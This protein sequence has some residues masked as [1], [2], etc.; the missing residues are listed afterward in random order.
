M[1][2]VTFRHVFQ[3]NDTTSE[4]L[5]RR[6]LLPLP[7]GFDATDDS[8]LAHLAEQGGHNPVGY[9]D[10]PHEDYLRHELLS[11]LLQAGSLHL[12]KMACVLSAGVLAVVKLLY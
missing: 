9:Q 3:G 8:L 4:V 6:E 11:P 12:K 2:D 7:G 5:G 1:G 10:A